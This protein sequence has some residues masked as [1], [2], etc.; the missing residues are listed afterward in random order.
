MNHLKEYQTA[1]IFIFAISSL[2]VM[3]TPQ[4]HAAG[5]LASP[6]KLQHTPTFCEVE[7]QDKNFPYMGIMTLSTTHDSIND[8][9]TQLNMGLGNKTVWNINEVPIPLSI[10]KNYNYTSCDVEISYMP[11]PVN[12]TEIL[13]TVGTSTFDLEKHKVSIIVYYSEIVNKLVP[14][15]NYGYESVVQYSDQPMSYLRLKQTISHEI[16]HALGLAHYHESKQ[17]QLDKWVS[18][19]E[20]PPSIMIEVQGAAEKY[21]GVTQNDVAQVKL[22]YGNN[23]F[24]GNTTFGLSHEL[25]TSDKNGEPIQSIPDLPNPENCPTDNSVGSGSESLLTK[26]ADNTGMTVVFNHTPLNLYEKCKN[27]WTFDF[28]NDKNPKQNMSN[29]YYDIMIQQDFM[30]SLAKEQGKNYFVAVNGRGSDEIEVKEREGVVYYWI[31]VY[32]TPPG[33]DTQGIV[34]GSALVFL[35]VAHKT[36][37]KTTLIQKE[38]EPWVRNIAEWWS[39]GNIQDP[40]FVQSL[41]YLIQEGFLKINKTSSLS[42]ETN[43]PPWL[44]QGAGL[45]AKGQISDKEFFQEI[46]YLTEN[47][48][49]NN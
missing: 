36:L 4:A 30:R 10:Q 42:N 48:I 49:I 6:F 47:G 19:K 43:I 20:A 45:W 23:G 41:Q 12:K 7:P 8:W 25:G 31:V 24:G 39:T 29:V 15:Q 21:F 32:S 38:M 1:I 17:E 5:Y 28:V 14:S 44:K 9:L 46:Q 16:G 3:V 22:K 27:M 2:L 18:G 33:K 37:P 40:E 35:N 26:T 11:Q 34:A 13:E